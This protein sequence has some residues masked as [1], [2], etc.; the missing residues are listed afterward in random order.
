MRTLMKV[1]IPTE[2]GNRA[3]KDGSLAAIAGKTLETVKAEAAYFATTDGLRTMLIVFDL[4]SP[5]DIPQIAEP[6]FLG[7]NA[8]VD[9]S[10][11]MNADDLKTGLSA[12][13]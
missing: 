11:C 9:F 13:K 4:K 5:S 7:L 6:L 1:R 2:D 3:L 10:P 8:M 12:L